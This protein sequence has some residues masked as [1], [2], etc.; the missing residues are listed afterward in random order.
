MTPEYPRYGGVDFHED[1][2]VLVRQLGVGKTFMFRELDYAKGYP[3]DLQL[4]ALK[5]IEHRGF[6][7]ASG[8]GVHVRFSATP[9]LLELRRID[10]AN[11][12]SFDLQAEIAG[13]DLSPAS[14]KRYLRSGYGSGWASKK[15]PAR[16]FPTKEEVLRATHGMALTENYP[17]EEGEEY[18][19]S[20]PELTAWYV[21]AYLD[22][23]YFNPLKP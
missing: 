9:A 21:K 22:R 18:Q 12:S 7:R 11:R 17:V 15:R 19:C 1:H 5:E 16:N 3:A 13:I 8:V 23:N 10:S 6:A 14:C 4:R 20:S 2:I